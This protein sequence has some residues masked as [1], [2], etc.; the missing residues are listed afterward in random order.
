MPP[1]Y[2]SGNPDPAWATFSS[3]VPSDR[4]VIE[5]G[6]AITAVAI[7]V[8]SELEF[9]ESRSS[10]L[11]TADPLTAGHPFIELHVL[12]AKGGTDNSATYSR[13]IHPLRQPSRIQPPSIGTTGDPLNA[14]AFNS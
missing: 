4:L 6:L 5:I 3:V 14:K 12:E 9:G 8:T 11:S 2:T 7:A 1:I 10:A 13:P